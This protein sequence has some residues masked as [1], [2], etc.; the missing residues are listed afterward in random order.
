MYHIFDHDAQHGPYSLEKLHAMRKSGL[1]SAEALYWDEHASQW[2][3]LESMLQEGS[4]APTRLQ[5]AQ[6]SAASASHVS[7]ASS[8]IK[9]RQAFKAADFGRRFIALCLDGAWMI[10]AAVL[11]SELARVLDMWAHE[12]TFSLVAFSAGFAFR[13]GLFGGRSLGRRLTFSYVVGREALEPVG[14]GQAIKRN[15]VSA[16]LIAAPCVIGGLVGL[17]LGKAGGKVGAGV[18]LAGLIAVLK[19][20][21]GEGGQSMWDEICGTL[22]VVRAKPGDQVLSPTLTP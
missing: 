11:A 19:S 22:V 5:A 7:A 14:L 17:L 10:A 12:G 1:V 3:S 9:S 21:A 16:L 20:A 18:I 15:L 8:R 6:P 2:L 4:V 13:D